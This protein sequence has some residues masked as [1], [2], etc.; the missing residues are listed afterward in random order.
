MGIIY[1][2]PI[3]IVSGYSEFPDEP[4]EYFLIN[5]YIED[6]TF[7]APENGYFKI[8]VFGASG[9]GGNASTG[10]A[11]QWFDENGIHY[12]IAGGASGGNGGYSCSVIKLSEGNTINLIIGASGSDTSATINSSLGSYTDITVTSG[13]NGGNASVSDPDNNSNTAPVA[14]GGTGGTGGVAIGGNLENIDGS[15]GVSGNINLYAKWNN[16]TVKGGESNTTIEGG[17]VGGNGAGIDYDTKYSA[18]SGQSGYIKIYR[19]HTNLYSM[20]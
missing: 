12:G 10:Q 13:G 15:D 18:G 4:I 3:K 14:S 1:G 20:K 19:G 17:T 11:Y 6:T 2:K 16:Q 5:T 9:K 7:T 8:E